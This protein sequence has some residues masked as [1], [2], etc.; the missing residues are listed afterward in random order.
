MKPR[1]EKLS[2]SS[3]G[4]L[5]PA[6]HHAS[7]PVH[8]PGRAALE[9]SQRVEPP[10]VFDSQEARTDRRSKAD[11]ARLHERSQT[12]A[13]H[14]RIQPLGMAGHPRRIR[15]GLI[16]A[17]PGS[18]RDPGS[19][20]S[21]PGE[22]AGASLKRD[23]RILRGEPLAGPI[24]GEFAGASLKRFIP[25]SP[26]I[27]GVVHPRR[28]RR[29][30]IEAGQWP[31]GRLGCRPAIP[32][33]FAGA[34]LKRRIGRWVDDLLDNHPRRIRRGLI[35]AVAPRTVPDSSTIHPRRIR[36]GLIEARD[37]RGSSR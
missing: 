14:A 16:E 10:P 32:G 13:S 20:R 19:G 27:P 2:S 12:D 15:R 5:A 4:R 28:I 24:P 36:R 21:I 25:F 7:A 37:A 34:S 6:G 3:H 22:F 1:I 17:H 8:A 30:L 11:Q 9:A 35:E 33:E 29:G 31:R 23:A 18:R 26:G